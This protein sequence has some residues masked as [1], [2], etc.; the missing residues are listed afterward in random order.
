MSVNLNIIYI[1]EIIILIKQISA[2][3]CIIDRQ[4]FESDSK[5]AKHFVKIDCEQGGHRRIQFGIIYSENIILTS[6]EYKVGEAVTCFIK[7][8]NLRGVTT[9]VRYK[10]ISTLVEVW[11][12]DSYIAEKDIL[13]RTSVPLKILLLRKKIKLHPKYA[14][15]MPLPESPYK[16]DSKCVVIGGDKPDSNTKIV[17]MKTVVIDR[18]ECES[19]Y[20]NLAE[21]IMCIEVPDEYC[22]LEHCDEYFEGSALVCD[23]VLTALVGANQPCF[24]LKPRTCVGIYD[25]AK[26]IQSFEE[27]ISSDQEHKKALVGVVLTAARKKLYDIGIILSK[28]KILTAYAPNLHDT[29][30]FERGYFSDYYEVKGYIEYGAG[31]IIDWYKARSHTNSTAF[32]PQEL[33]LSVIMLN[34]D[35]P[36]S[37]QTAY[38]MRLPENAPR[39]NAK[40][41]IATLYPRWMKFSLTL[42]D[43][44]E[45]V[46]NLPELHKDYMC[47]RQVLPRLDDCIQ[48]G[49]PIICDGE[50]TAIVAKMINCK[51]NYP[52]PVAPIHR[53]RS[54][55]LATMRDL[56]LSGS[57]QSTF[58]WLLFIIIFIIIIPL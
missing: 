56:E 28:N 47:I 43:Y 37:P 22:N 42:M 19:T 49:N 32:T 20:P 40:C 12:M 38:S 33:Q 23:G 6:N 24:P 41:I 7:Y 57:E 16:Q 17:E 9:P 52:R 31:Q 55:I 36:L 35:I 11:R 53:Y 3:S 21:N 10:T 54:W 15:P 14:A 25:A 29:R 30:I 51:K 39:K 26:W 8:K 13:P 5:M 4:L 1:F 50:L 45:C 2:E 46:K 58:A 48:S 27:L 34:E 44:D 18:K